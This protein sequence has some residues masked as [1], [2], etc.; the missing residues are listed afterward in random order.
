LARLS[1]AVALL[2]AGCS[3]QQASLTPSPPGVLRIVSS[4]PSRGATAQQTRDIEDAIRS[5]LLQRGEAAG[6][7][8]IEYVALHDSDDETGDWSRQKELD[9]A[10][11]AA[12]D[13][14]VVAYIGPYNSGAAMLAIPVTNRSGL[15]ELSPSATWPGLTAQGWDPGEPEKYYP[16]GRRTFL[17]LMPSDSTQ[18]AAAAQWAAG[19]GRSHVIVL[20][21]GSS[22]SAGLAK[23]FETSATA[24]GVP[25]SNTVD[26]KLAPGAVVASQLE[27]SPA[28]FYAPSSVGNA[29]ALARALQDSPAVVY[30]TDTALDPQFVAQAGAAARNWKIVSNSAPPDTKGRY[31][32][33]TKE[34]Q[35]FPTQFAANAYDATNLVL[36][37]VAS[38]P[39]PDR[40]AILN[41]VRDAAVT[42]NGSAQRLFNDVGDPQ[43]GTLSGYTVTPAGLKLDRTLSGGLATPTPSR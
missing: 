11:S 43:T 23:E 17:R 24:L 21:D 22:Y 3:Q 40:P 16:S 14:G 5:A 34:G 20:E 9:N 30:A 25:V 19:D 1:V 42:R 6:G 28:Y 2:A 4:L 8:N 18:A 10:S 12:N 37:A 29:I 27:P 26:L 13:P 41:Y 32:S 15:L 36:D 33:V 35:T 38:I 31:P 39:H 7:T